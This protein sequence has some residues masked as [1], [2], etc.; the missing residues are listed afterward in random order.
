MFV[1]RQKFYIYDVFVQRRNSKIVA[2]AAQSS[3][4][5]TSLFPQHIRQQLMEAKRRDH[6]EKQTNGASHVG[7]KSRIKSFLSSGP[8]EHATK[9]A[10][11]GGLSK[12]IAD[13]YLGKWVWYIS[14]DHHRCFLRLTRNTIIMNSECTVMFAE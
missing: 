10:E 3:A 13:L 6:Q 2:N 14:P 5:V 11:V 1:T 12:P 7:T 8:E 4:I 9:G